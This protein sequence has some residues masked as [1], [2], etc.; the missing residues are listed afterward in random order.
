MPQAKLFK[1]GNSVVLAIPEAMR[2]EHALKAGDT[3]LLTTLN[4]EIPEL[5]QI[6]I[7]IQKPPQ[8]QET[9]THARKPHNKAR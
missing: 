9:K 5:T 2:H 3:V 7:L 1:N 8:P 4:S 6:V